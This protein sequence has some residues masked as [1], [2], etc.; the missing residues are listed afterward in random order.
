MEMR[1]SHESGNYIHATPIENV[2]WDN[3][4][5][6]S[7]LTAALNE[8]RKA[9]ADLARERDEAVA[10]EQALRKFAG[11]CIWG[12]KNWGGPFKDASDAVAWYAHAAGDALNS[13]EPNGL[14]A[15]LQEA[16]RALHLYGRHLHRCSQDHDCEAC[17]CGFN[18][19]LAALRDGG[20]IKETTQM[21]EAKAHKDI[22]ERGKQAGI[23]A[24][25]AV[26]EN[27]PR[28]RFWG[29]GES[30]CPKDIQA[31]NGELHT[32]R[33]KV[34]GVDNPRDNICFAAIDTALREGGGKPQYN[35]VLRE[36]VGRTESFW[37]Y[38]QGEHGVELSL[39]ELEGDH[40]V[41]GFF[42]ALATAKAALREGGGVREEVGA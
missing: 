7:D 24:Y 34:C 1:E 38:I 35:A 36:L 5:I 27:P 19:A 41:S 20:G 9:N 17:N 12:G 11:A 10:R 14:A 22:F 21:T 8:L 16:E 13:A 23:A 37:A 4:K 18:A 29:A 3:D 6:I 32:I 33:C 42:E 28:H 40:N 15:R 2:Q 25:R 26:M 30:D 39:S 31:G